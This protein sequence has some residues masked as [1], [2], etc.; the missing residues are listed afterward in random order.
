MA[1]SDDLCLI[2]AS[3]WL[4]GEKSGRLFV[5]LTYGMVLLAMTPVLP[6]SRAHADA[7]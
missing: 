3:S 5:R 7:C 1:K 6:P 4:R 2:F